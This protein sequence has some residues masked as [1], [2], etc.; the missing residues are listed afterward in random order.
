MNEEEITNYGIL[1]LPAPE[2]EVNQ[3]VDEDGNETDPVKLS[4]FE[5]KY[6]L[7]FCFQTWCQGSR[8][9]GFPIMQKLVSA[10]GSNKNILFLAIQTA[11]EGLESNTFE[12][13]KAFQK[14]YSLKIPFGHDVG[15]T[16]T[17][18]LPSTLINYNTGGTPWFILID[19]ENDVVFND[20]GIDAKNVIAH[21]EKK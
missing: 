10:L 16:N 12:K 7:L 15:D 19:P 18:L 17:G 21:F 8:E 4:Q 13:A 2:L 20:Y 1:D 5:G 9:E 6:K 3:W 11:F 14:Q